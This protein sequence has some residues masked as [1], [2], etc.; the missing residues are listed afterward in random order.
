L[1]RV[2]S[3]VRAA[4]VSAPNLTSC[5]A[6]GLECLARWHIS[7]PAREVAA[8]SFQFAPWLAHWEVFITVKPIPRK[9]CP[10]EKD[11]QASCSGAKQCPYEISNSSSG[12][13]KRGPCSANPEGRKRGRQGEARPN[14]APVTAASDLAGAVSRSYDFSTAG[15]HFSRLCS[16]SVD[17]GFGNLGESSPAVTI[18]S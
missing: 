13:S 7:K 5:D 4:S 3:D 6:I 15:E 18:R 14:Q 2:G 17:Q 1:T 12:N 16:F 10:Q 8:V 11:T 9:G